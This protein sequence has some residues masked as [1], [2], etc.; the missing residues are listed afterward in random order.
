MIDTLVEECCRLLVKEPCLTPTLQFF[1]FKL[2]V[3]SLGHSLGCAVIP[4]CNKLQESALISVDFIC[5][6]ADMEK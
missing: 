3:Q 2:L 1:M 6:H 5:L 4:M